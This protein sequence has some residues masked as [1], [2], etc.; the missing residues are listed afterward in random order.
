MR[1]Y[2]RAVWCAVT[3]CGSYLIAMLQTMSQ[4]PRRSVGIHEVVDMPW[5]IYAAIPSAVSLVCILLFIVIARRSVSTERI[6]LLLVGGGS[7]VL[8]TWF[9]LEMLR[10]HY[11]G[12][13]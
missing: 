6:A 2:H 9:A 5:R 4:A 8:C 1:S 11:V 7:V 13:L 10:L 3:A 12:K